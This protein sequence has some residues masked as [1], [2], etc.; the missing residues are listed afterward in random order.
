MSLLRIQQYGLGNYTAGFCFTVSN[1]QDADEDTFNNAFASKTANNTLQGNQSIQGTLDV[2]GATTL[3]STLGVT[4]DTTVANF[5]ATGTMTKSGVDVVTTTGTQTLSNKTIS[6]GNVNSATLA[7]NTIS[8][9]T[10]SNTAINNST[11]DYGLVVSDTNYLELPTGATADFSGMTPNAGNI[12]VDTDKSLLVV[13]YGAGFI[14]QVDVSTAQTLTN[15]TLTSP[16]LN[17]SV[18]GTAV[19]D[20]DNMASD[21][22]TK[23]ATQQS[24]KAYVDSSVASAG[25][26]NEPTQLVNVGIAASAS[27]G[28]LTVSLKQSDGSTDPSTGTAAVIIGYR[29]STVTNGGYSQVSTTAS[30]SVVIPSGAT[31]GYADASDNFVHVYAINNAGATELAVCGSAYFNEDEVVSTTAIGTGSDSGNVLYSTSARSNVPCR[32]LGYFRIDSMT[33]AGTWTAP[34]LAALFAKNEITASGSLP[35]SS[36][37]SGTTLTAENSFVS[38]DSTGG[39]FTVTLPPASVCAGRV[40]KLLKTDTSSNVITVDG[41]ASETIFGKTT[42]GLVGK[43]DF[44]S[45]ISNGS[46]WVS[47]DSDSAHRVVSVSIDNDGSSTSTY[48]YPDGWVSSLADPATGQVTITFATG[49]FSS[50]PVVSPSAYRVLANTRYTVSSWISAI[51]SSAVTIQWAYNDDQQGTI[52]AAIA[53]T[54]T[55]AEILVQIHGPR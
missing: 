14:D 9:G 6:G 2:T 12:G 31:L 53:N 52:A 20:E 30:L 51:S 3:N 22:A 1:G 54:D 15:K 7:S 17:T 43:N 27:A 29:S 48:E 32:Y 36:I 25:G 13:D 41:N 33:T 18:S 37:T 38:M 40:F 45:I 4:G 46:N 16:V 24:I 35:F 42:V 44:I 26:N 47:A 28:A 34:T 50:V 5:N 49:M 21:S 55:S 19:L 39:A 11:I 8:G 10:V 23:L